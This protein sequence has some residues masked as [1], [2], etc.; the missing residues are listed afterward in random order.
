M[1]G[2]TGPVVYGAGVY[3]VWR[4]RDSATLLISTSKSA[5]KSIWTAVLERLLRTIISVR[6]FWERG[7]ESVRGYV[8]GW[9]GSGRERE[10][11]YGCVC[12]CVH[13]PVRGRWQQTRC[14]RLLTFVWLPREI[15]D[16]LVFSVYG[17]V[18]GSSGAGPR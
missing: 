2:L 11:V 13:V 4:R 18:G 7:R 10:G 8:G 14:F 3:D 6:V 12:M 17:L 5:D 16:P 15:V 1:L 9:G